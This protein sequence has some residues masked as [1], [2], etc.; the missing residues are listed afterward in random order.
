MV[1]NV[2]PHTERKSLDSGASRSVKPLVESQGIPF[3]GRTSLN[4]PLLLLLC[5]IIMQLK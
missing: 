5:N 1:F 2:F 4:M 3:N